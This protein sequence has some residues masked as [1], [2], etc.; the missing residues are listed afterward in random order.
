MH[1]SFTIDLV[2]ITICLLF[3]ASIISI[4]A[5]KTGF[6]F[7]ILL[8]VIGLLISWFANINPDLIPVRLFKLT[9]DVVFFVFLPALIFE[10]AFNLDARKLLRNIVPV[11]TLAVPALLIS[12]TIV[13]TMVH[14]FL[15]LPLGVSLLFGALISATDPVAVVALFKD[16]GAPKR[17]NLL[18]EGESLFNDATAL[19]L[20]KIILGVVLVGHFSTQ[21]VL[22]GIGSFFIV[23]F[24]GIGVGCILGL[25][26]AKLI[27][28]VKNEPLVEITLTTILAHSTFLFA[29][30]TFHVSGVMATVAAGLTMGGYGRN[31]ISP[32]VREHMESF[33]E[34][35][36]FVCNSLIF[37]L[38]GLSIDMHLFIENFSSIL[39]AAFA[40]LIARG[41]AVYTLFPLIARFRTVEAVDKK[42]QTVIFWGGL[43]GALAIAIALSIPEELEERSFIL[44][45]T[46][47]V[48]L[49]T[50]VV[51]GLTIKPLMTLLGLNRYSTTEQFER[52][53]AMLH[54]RHK[55]W[56]DMLVFAAMGAIEQGSIKKAENAYNLESE[57]ISRE[58]TSLR[59]ND[60]IFSQSAESDMVMRHALKFERIQYHKL[61]EQGLLKENNLKEITHIIDNELDRIKEGRPV[62]GKG[63][64]PSIFNQLEDAFFNTFGKIFLFRNMLL[65][66]KTGK[67]AASYERKTARI[68]AIPAILK[69]LQALKDEKT[70]PEPAINSTIAFY[71]KIQKMV[72]ERLSLLRGEYPEYVEKVEAGIIK[73][74]CLNSEME[75]LR[76]LYAKGAITEKVLREKEQDIEST[77]RKMRMR[78]IKSLFLSPPEMISKIPG[79]TALE[80]QELD[81]L[82]SHLRAV[83]YMAGEI[84]VKEGESG[85]SM[86]IIGRGQVDILKSNSSGKEKKVGHLVTGDFFGEIALLHP[87]P[88]TATVVAATPVILLK[89]WRNDILPYLDEAPHFKKAMEEAYMER[90]DEVKEKE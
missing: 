2:S 86:Y 77:T 32:P 69:E 28:A 68:I 89:L 79:F 70:Y 62:M 14:Y 65:K 59:E 80:R 7:T 78:P 76:E 22:T 71:E 30:H 55:A 58:L 37:L 18:V 87:Q 61:F 12:T 36:A 34:Y 38:V 88:R 10:S 52:L 72:T 81:R 4:A 84:I 24:G 74:C 25:F 67:I 26:F 9:P 56:Q 41:V 5:K 13:G 17:L 63:E 85:E 66:Y 46:L 3:I 39:L 19:V 16:M 73:R 1:S 43:R 48:V 60:E 75:T 31:K 50:L 90:K 33:W 20:F 49:F 54:A 64:A 15:A 40:M 11:M 29:E 21:T 23:F 57:K 82:S 42:F 8:V 35:F 44:I 45:L 53:Q 47:G 83:S 6:P 51:N 27:E